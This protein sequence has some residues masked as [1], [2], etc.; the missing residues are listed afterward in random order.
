MRTHHILNMGAGRQTT[1][2]YLMIADGDLNIPCDYAVFS[3][4]QEEESWLYDHLEWLKTQ[5]GPP[6]ITVTC[7]N[8]GDDLLRGE[9]STGQKF[10]TIPAFTSNGQGYVGQ[11]RRQ[12][13]SEYKIVPIEK[14][15]RYDLIGLQ[16][17]QHM[18]K[19]VLVT[20]YMGFSCDEPGRAARAK[21]RFK[22]I[23]WGEVEFPLMDEEIWM[24]EQ[25]CVN[26]CEKRVPHPVLKSA[27]VFCPY[28][29]N[30]GWLRLKKNNPDGFA[31][32]VEIDDGMRV[33]GRI[34]NRN[35]EAQL[36]LH[37]ACKPLK[38]ISFDEQQGN[39][40]DKE[41]EGGC[42]L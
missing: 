20:H 17:G 3:D 35:L 38:D 8:L 11:T 32:A 18:P 15:M 42:G 41:C 13:T 14:W 26:Y 10:A 27:C 12:C 6:L 9:N 28:K 4:T 37:R 39:L 40:F 23:R 24:T 16:P 25:D 34:V 5:G 22:Q 36:Y 29:S 1:A 19:D 30:A 33:P 31:R 7:S 2:L 21:M